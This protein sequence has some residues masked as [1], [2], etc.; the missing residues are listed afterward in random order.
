LLQLTR[1]VRMESQDTG[2]A[3]EGVSPEPPKET[4]KKT[5]TVWVFHGHVGIQT[6]VAPYWPRHVSVAGAGCHSSS[7]SGL[8]KIRRSEAQGLRS[9]PLARA[10]AVPHCCSCTSACI[11]AVSLFLAQAPPVRT[12]LP[13]SCDVPVC[14]GSPFVHWFPSTRCSS[15]A[16]HFLGVCLR[17]AASTILGS[18]ASFVRILVTSTAEIA[19]AFPKHTLTHFWGRRP[20]GRRH[21]ARVLVHPM[22]SQ[23]RSII[24]RETHC[25]PM[26]LFLAQILFFIKRWMIGQ[27]PSYLVPS[28]GPRPS[29]V[30]TLHPLSSSVANL[31]DS[32][33][34]C[35]PLL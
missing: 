6:H 9:R 13:F 28:S 4:G 2:R 31:R 32:S 17:L 33:C 22:T 3:S 15:T 14:T 5:E 26:P 35:P 34:G 27:T 30:E 29:D 21:P 8:A 11:E 20:P 12:W 19:S 18:P 24:S 25:K 23:C 16:S 10:R 1:H 7:H